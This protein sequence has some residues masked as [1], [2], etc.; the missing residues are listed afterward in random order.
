MES[1]FLWPKRL[2][3]FFFFSVTVNI[4]PVMV[5]GKLNNLIAFFSKAK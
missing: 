5:K 2:R 3:Y 1:K 4:V